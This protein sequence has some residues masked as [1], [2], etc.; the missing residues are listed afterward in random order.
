MNHFDLTGK[1]TMVTG[2]GRGIGRAIPEALADHGAAVVI[3]DLT[4]TEPPN[5]TRNVR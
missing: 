3:C 1:I 4:Y 2:G 5:P